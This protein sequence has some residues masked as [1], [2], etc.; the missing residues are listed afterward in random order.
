MTKIN[1]FIWGF[2]DVEWMLE[3]LSNGRKTEAEKERVVAAALKKIH[4][5]RQRAEGDSCGNP[6]A[7]Q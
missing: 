3:M 7:E 5:A 2:D 4:N 1:D 6:R